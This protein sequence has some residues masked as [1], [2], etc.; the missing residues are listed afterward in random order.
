M[1][2]FVPRL[3]TLVFEQSKF[4]TE[5]SFRLKA[6]FD[7]NRMNNGTPI[8][9]HIIIVRCSFHKAIMSQRDR[10][11]RASRASEAPL[12]YLVNDEIEARIPR[13]ATASPSK[14]SSAESRDRKLQLRMIDTKTSTKRRKRNFYVIF[15]PRK[16]EP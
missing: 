6:T 13:V 8:T 5:I 15:V 10:L 2:F 11:V 12:I 1:A 16:N 7:F 3:R 9:Y 14:T 4:R